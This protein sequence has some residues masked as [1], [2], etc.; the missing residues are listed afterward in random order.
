MTKERYATFTVHPG[1]MTFQTSNLEVSGDTSSAYLRAQTHA[2]KEAG[3]T[4]RT[5]CVMKGNFRCGF[6]AEDIF[7]RTSHLFR[8]MQLGYAAMW[9]YPSRSWIPIMPED[10]TVEEGGSAGVSNESVRVVR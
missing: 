3:E 5:T 6:G 4:Q 10:D 1:G 8:I 9:D 2:A 7:D